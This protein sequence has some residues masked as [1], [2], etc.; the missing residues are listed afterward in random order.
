MCGGLGRRPALRLGEPG[1]VG[2]HSTGTPDSKAGHESVSARGL[3]NSGHVLRS[4]GE[5]GQGS[6]SP[7]ARKLLRGATERDCEGLY[8]G[9]P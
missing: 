4:V 8:D 5:G 7:D 2:G 6:G 3:Q 9:M 1:A